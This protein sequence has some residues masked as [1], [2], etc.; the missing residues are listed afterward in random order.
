MIMQKPASTVEEF[1]H[2]QNLKDWPEDIITE[3]DFGPL[4]S[5]LDPAYS[6][7]EISEA[8]R[9]SVPLQ[10]AFFTEM[11]VKIGEQES[12]LNEYYSQLFMPVG[13]KEQLHSLHGKTFITGIDQMYGA[14]A[15]TSMMR[16]IE[17]CR[18][19]AFKQTCLTE[20]PGGLEAPQLL[21]RVTK[22]QHF[23]ARV[24]KF[25]KKMFLSEASVAV[26]QDSFWWFF[27]ERF[28][29][30]KEDQDHLYDRIADSFF[31]LFWSI[32]HNVKDIFFKVYADCLSQAIFA[33]F[34]DAF[35]KSH[36]VFGDDF[37]NNLMD[38]I[39]QWV[40]GIRP[41]PFSWKTWNFTLLQSPCDDDVMADKGASLRRQLD[42]NLDDLIRDAKVMH[43]ETG[44]AR[45]DTKSGLNVSTENAI[46]RESH[47]IGPGPDFST[48]IF[49]LSSRSPLISH[50]LKMHEITNVQTGFHG[51]KLKRV[52]VCNLPTPSAPTY[53][54]VI[55]EAEAF[56]KSLRK[57]YTALQDKTRKEIE[58]IEQQKIR[59]N[60]QFERL[61]N[62]VSGGNRQ[63]N[64]LLL[65]KMEKI[66][67]FSSIFNKDDASE[68][69]IFKHDAN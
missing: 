49:K 44:E 9:K 53:Q 69:D 65:E 68:E 39:F 46:S 14:S 56:R 16:K 38:T 28:Q 22:A 8:L 29:P 57:D 48:V 25:W 50:Y 40:S 42:F 5:K 26:L 52:E 23:K 4:E 31:T 63:Y 20:L 30:N 12:L 66:S 43:K 60:R 55:K 61:K 41:P 3:D 34:C 47:S 67:F 59:V 45:E 37:K 27:L 32:H 19:P 11:E 33:V 64:A 1:M 58:E 10:S 51:Q 13:T 62:E 2:T 35:P 6:L 18:F 21:N 54:D 7:D 24:S 17:H 15:E 36:A